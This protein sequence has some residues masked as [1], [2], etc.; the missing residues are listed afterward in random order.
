MQNNSTVMDRK[1]S[2]RAVTVQVS[3]PETNYRYDIGFDTAE[4]AVRAITKLEQR[5]LLLQNGVVVNIE[6][7]VT[8]EMKPATIN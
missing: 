2:N 1:L 7:D 4:D 8:Y 3:I 5:Q 6:E